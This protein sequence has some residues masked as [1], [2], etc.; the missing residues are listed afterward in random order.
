MRTMQKKQNNNNKFLTDNTQLQ[1]PAEL[2]FEI[3][4]LKAQRFLTAVSMTHPTHVEDVSR[5][6]WLRAWSRVCGRS[7]L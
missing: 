6:L 5:Q 7:R 1:N 3:G 4:S 2:M